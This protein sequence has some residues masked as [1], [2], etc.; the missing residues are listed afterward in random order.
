M[1][2]LEY[3]TIVFIPE[4]K[5]E[6]LDTA[7]TTAF[8]SLDVPDV[9]VYLEGQGTKTKLTDAGTEITGTQFKFRLRKQTDSMNVQTDLEALADALVQIGVEDD[10]QTAQETTV[11]Q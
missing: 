7:A 8:D 9:D 4:G 2:T 10:T 3:S 5:E 1:A 11:I 6:L